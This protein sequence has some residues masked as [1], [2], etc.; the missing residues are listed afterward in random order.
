MDY[1]ELGRITVQHEGL[2]VH[3]KLQ[4]RYDEQLVSYHCLSWRTL[5][6]SGRSNRRFYKTKDSGFW[7]LPISLAFE[8]M[9]EA[10]NRGWLDD[11]Y[12]DPQIRHGGSNNRVL[13]SRQLVDSERHD[14]FESI[15]CIGEES[16][17]GDS[18]VFIVIEVPDGKWRKI[19][20]VDTTRE[21]VT[22]RSTTTDPCYRPVIVDSQMNPWRMDGAMQ[23]ASALMTRSFLRL[24]RDE[25]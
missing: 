21:F 1:R 17:W 4:E 10:E 3:F 2:P 16:D 24:L 11:N 19:M 7:T 14:L 8:A 23:D 15:T 25:F 6:P 13:D 18:P 9:S 22:F 5:Y 12:D 20:I